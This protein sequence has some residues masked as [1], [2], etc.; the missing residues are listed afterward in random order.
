MGEVAKLTHFVQQFCWQCDREVKFLCPQLNVCGLE[1]ADKLITS[2]TD[3][4]R[5]NHLRLPSSHT[6]TTF[7][8][9]PALPH[10]SVMY[11]RRVHYTRPIM[12]PVQVPYVSLFSLGFQAKTH[13]KFFQPKIRAV[14]QF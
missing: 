7:T 9:N 3:P 1:E 11:Y 13:W 14:F 6:Y 12:I 2:F 8:I 5:W 10:R 4:W